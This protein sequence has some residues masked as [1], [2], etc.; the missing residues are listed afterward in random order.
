VFEG[1]ADL[2]NT[3]GRQQTDDEEDENPKMNNNL[4]FAVP[5][6]RSKHF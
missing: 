4:L 2:W 6:N 1:E 5:S 3:W